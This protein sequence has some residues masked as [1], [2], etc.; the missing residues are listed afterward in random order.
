MVLSDLDGMPY[1]I[2]DCYLNIVFVNRLYFFKLVEMKLER[3]INPPILQSYNLS[4]KD[5][6]AGGNEP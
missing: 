1:N 3:I 2:V 4:K 5:A 6:Q